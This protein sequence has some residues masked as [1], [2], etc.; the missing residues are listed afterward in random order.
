[1]KRMIIVVLIVTAAAL[2]AL[3]APAQEKKIET[4][5]SETAKAETPQAEPQIS[6]EFHD[7]IV[8]LLKVIGSESLIRQY[9]D[10]FSRMIIS[11]LRSADDKLSQKEID[12]VKEE[13]KKFMD[14]KFQDLI[15]NLVPIYANHFTMDEVRGISAFYKSPAGMKAIKEFPLI[16]RESMATSNNWGK[17]VSSDVEQRVMARLE[18]EGYKAPKP[19]EKIAPQEKK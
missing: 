9:G 7:E 1:M 10:S 6:K 4:Q 11:K 17:S 15:E 16:T 12:L 14:E 8:Q 2:S 5:T 19:E 13:T 3:V 18:K